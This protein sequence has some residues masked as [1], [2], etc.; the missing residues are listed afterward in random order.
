MFAL[1]AGARGYCDR[2]IAP[3]QLKKAVEVVQRGEIWIGRHV[4]PHLL[5]RITSL[6]PAGPDAGPGARLPRQLRLPRPARAR[7][8]APRRL[9]SEQQ[10]D[11]GA[12][13][14]HRVDGEGASHLRLP[15][16]RRPGPAAP[17]S[18]RAASAS[19]DGRSPRS[20]AGA[21]PVDLAPGR[22]RDPVSTAR[23]RRVGHRSS[24]L[25]KAI[26]HRYR[27]RPGSAGRSCTRADGRSAYCVSP[28]R[29][30]ELAV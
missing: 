25:G 17:G 20:V 6:T 30:Q 22:S 9:G 4:V 7:D 19:A 2:N 12:A 21:A 18:L 3:S 15:Q 8:R 1:V 13:R 24:T 5:R 26:A 11:C 27:D 29:A 10:R 14:H 16:A 28:T 23:A